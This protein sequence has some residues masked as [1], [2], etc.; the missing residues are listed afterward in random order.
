MA[1]RPPTSAAGVPSVAETCS[2]TPSAC[3]PA[4]AAGFTLVELLVVVVI[5]LVLAGLTGAAVSSARGA[6]KQRQTQAL[7]AK[8]DAIVANHFANVSTRSIPA[9]AVVAGMSRDAL[10]RRQITADLPDTWADARAAAADPAQFPS[11]AVRAYGGVLQS[12][13]PTDQYADAECLFMIV[14]Q[15]GIAGCIDCSELTSAEIGDIDND[16]A[17][18]FK[19]GWGNPIR[20]ILWPAGLE[21]PVGTRFFVS[22]N[23]P[24]PLIWSAGADGRGSLT[25]NAG[26]NL[27]MAG[28][29]G[30]PAN[31][32]VLTFGGWDKAS[33]DGRADNVTNLDAEAQP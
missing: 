2:P 1:T 25:I 28:E 26:S 27:G 29:C 32:K 15:G 21:L 17:P 8:I 9:G 22:P 16:R 20:F 30:N 24:R 31:A 5:I 10:V 23:P 13:N 33:P 19:D 18:E 6:A 14:M 7:I 3:R 4:P 11:T 12:F